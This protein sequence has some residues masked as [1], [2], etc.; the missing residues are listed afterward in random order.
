MALH[1]HRM[2]EEGRCVCVC[3]EEVH[4]AW[5]TLAW[6]IW[7]IQDNTWRFNTGL[8]FFVGFFV[9]RPKL[10]RSQELQQK[11]REKNV[12]VS[13]T[14]C[15]LLDPILSFYFQRKPTNPKYRWGKNTVCQGDA[16]GQMAALSFPNLIQVLPKSP[17]WKIRQTLKPLKSKSRPSPWSHSERPD[18]LFEAFHWLKTLLQSAHLLTCQDCPNRRDKW[19]IC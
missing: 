3:G 16:F 2:S 5:S 4:C 17:H 15:T 7:G 13:C 11:R 8:F 10:G 9:L 6:L 14:T 19:S 12:G 1:W 18:G